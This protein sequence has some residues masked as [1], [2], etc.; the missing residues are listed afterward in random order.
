MVLGQRHHA[1]AI[2]NENFRKL[3][4]KLSKK[5]CFL[6]FYTTNVYMTAFLYFVTRAYYL[7]SFSK[8]AIIISIIK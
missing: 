7:L 8:F 3:E 5:A 4:N 6:I 1:L 2:N